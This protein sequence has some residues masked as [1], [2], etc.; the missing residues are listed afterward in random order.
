MNHWQLE[1]PLDAVT[2]DCDGTLSRCEGI[3]ELAWQNGVGPVVE[4]LTSV[5]MAKTGLTDD[6]YAERLSLVQPNR[7][8]VEALGDIYFNECV[9]MAAEVIDLFQRLGKQVYIISAGLQPSVAIFADHLRVPQSNVF[10]VNVYFDKAGNY[11]EFDQSSSL[12]SLGGK[13]EL[14]KE[15]K[16]K[17]PSILHVGDGMNDVDAKAQVKR[18]VGYGGIYYREQIRQCSDFYI[19][20]LSLAPLLPLSLTQEESTFLVGKDKAIYDEGVRL[21]LED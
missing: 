9:P 5:A 13:H 6:L 15:I 2:F 18:F 1:K 19:R 14:L 12:T 21:L 11:L 20:S 4:Q 7:L 10:A 8:Q 16:K 3:N 17:G